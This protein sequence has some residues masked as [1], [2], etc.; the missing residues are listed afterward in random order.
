[1]PPAQRSSLVGVAEIHQVQAVLLQG[2]GEAVAAGK[3][4]QIEMVLLGSGPCQL[5]VSVVEMQTG[6]GRNLLHQ[7]EKHIEERPSGAQ[8]EAELL[9]NQRPF[10]GDAGRNQAEGSAAVVMLHIAVPGGD[11][12]D[13]RD[14]AA[15][16]RRKIPFVEV[17]PAQDVVV[18]HGYETQEMAGAIERNPVQQD[19]ILV[20]ESAAD[21]KA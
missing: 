10:E 5:R 11:V 7:R 2:A 18:E 14:A 21:R 15:V 9:L 13:R 6:P 20:D 4:A 12:E 16:F 17:S 8:A 19:E 3:A 1:M